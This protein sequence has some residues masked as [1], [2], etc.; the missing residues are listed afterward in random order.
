MS[1]KYSQK[2]LYHA[3]QSATDA[4]KTTS[5]KVI[6]KTAEAAGDLIG[7]RIADEVTK[8]SKIPSRIIQ[9]QLQINLIKK[10]LKKDTYIQKKG[11]KLLMIYLL[12]YLGRVPTRTG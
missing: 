9:K 10:Y 6:Q 1:G 7:N 2:L 12:T 5:R 3:K 11:R 8:I 4:L